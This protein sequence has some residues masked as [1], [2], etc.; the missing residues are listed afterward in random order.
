[1]AGAGDHDRGGAR[2]VRDGQAALRAHRLSGPRGLYQEHDHG[3]R[4]DGWGDSG[5]GGER[6]ADAPNAR[7]CAAGA[8]GQRAVSGGVHEQGGHGGRPGDFGPGGAGG[9]PRH[10]Q[11]G[12][13]GGRDVPQAL[14]RGAGGGQYRGAAAGD[15]QGRSGAGPS[16][17]QARDDQTPQEIQGRGVRADEGR[18]GA[19]HAVLQRVPAAGLLSDDGRD[20]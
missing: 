4:P 1:R 12:G 15:R 6:W 14:G 5:G 17:G 10:A 16:I 7:A 18:G 19:A 2:G 13:D 20:G 9:D 11:D 3:G 8:P